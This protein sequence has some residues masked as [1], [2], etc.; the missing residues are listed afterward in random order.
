MNITAIKTRLVHAN[1]CPVEELVAESISHL[2]DASIVAVSSKV[3]AL[4]QGRVVDKSAINK[5]DLVKQEADY[6]TLEGFKK[7]GL[8][9][10]IT[11]NTLISAAGIDESNADDYFVLWPENPQRVANELRKFLCKRFNLR[12]IGVIITDSSSMPP[13]RAGA[14]G[15]MLAHSGFT[16]VEHLASTEDLFGRAFKVAKSATGSGLAAAANVVMGEGIEQ[17][18]I[19]V[20]TNVPFVTFQSRNPTSEELN[21]TYLPLEEDI[22]A[23]FLQSAPWQEG[24]HGYHS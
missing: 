24:G 13:M 1:E 18:P 15:I 2:N 14:I 6:Y 21:D 17:T 8:C 23:P 5:T 12:H 22:Y 11:N 20:I 3:I 19:A 10:T 16:A 4:C 9:F 7:H